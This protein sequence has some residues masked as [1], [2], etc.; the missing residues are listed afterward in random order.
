MHAAHALLPGAYDDYLT[1][2]VGL[3]PIFVRLSNVI[4]EHSVRT[5][6]VRTFPTRRRATALR[7]AQTAVRNPEVDPND[8]HSTIPD[9]QA[10]RAR[11]HRQRPRADACWLRDNGSDTTRNAGSPSGPEAA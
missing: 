11:L 10:S 8:H 3:N 4:P 5:V 7:L 2:I 9:E 1:L 6:S